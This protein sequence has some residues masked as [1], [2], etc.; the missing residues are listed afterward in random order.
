M[1]D[2]AIGTPWGQM[3]V[4]LPDILRNRPFRRRQVVVPDESGVEGKM[5]STLG[6]LAAGVLWPRLGVVSI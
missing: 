4:L 3:A 6:R 5:P 2:D 1:L